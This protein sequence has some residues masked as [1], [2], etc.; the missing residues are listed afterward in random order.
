MSDPTAPRPS[1]RALLPSNVTDPLLWR[2]AV[3]V[4]TAHQL[5]PDDRCVNLQCADQSGPCRAA[6]MAQRAMRSSRTPNPRPQRLPHA[7]VRER[8]PQRPVRDCGG[9]VGWF[10][11]RV[12]AT[13]THLRQRL[14]RRVP[15]AT[16]TA[17][18]AA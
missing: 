10:T 8:T 6:R 4:A 14:P 3:D 16:L 5:G 9:F 2:L 1:D 17:A 13:T 11:A 7:A 12:T 15:G 18:Y